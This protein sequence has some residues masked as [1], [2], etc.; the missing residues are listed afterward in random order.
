MFNAQDHEMKIHRI[1]AEIATLYSEIINI[2]LSTL[3]ALK[4]AEFENLNEEFLKELSDF[5]VNVKYYI[6]TFEKIFEGG[7]NGKEGGN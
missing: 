3:P 7:G 5:F 4:A 1:A 2:D 6:L